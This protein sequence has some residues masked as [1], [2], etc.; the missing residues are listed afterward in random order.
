MS[1]RF[2]KPVQTGLGRLHDTLEPLTG[3]PDATASELFERHAT[4]LAHAMTL[5]F[6]SDDC[7]DLYE[8]ESD[9]FSETD[10]LTSAILFGV[11][12]GWMELPLELRS[13]RE[14][15]DAVAHRMAHLSH[16]LSGTGVDLGDAPP[17][18][19]PLRE[20][21]GDGGNRRSRE[22]PR[23]CGLSRHRSGTAAFIPAGEAAVP[24]PGPQATPPRRHGPR[25]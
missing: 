4:P 17:R 5:F 13:G 25:R 21:F 19:R 11:R 1:E 8:Y 2:E 12:D 18:V 22:K 3:L 14:I 7:A 9:R 15:S 24:T 20:L 16:L 6:I 10:W 23:R